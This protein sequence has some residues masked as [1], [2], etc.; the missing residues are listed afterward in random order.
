MR[1]S[2]TYVYDAAER[3]K[4]IFTDAGMYKYVYNTENGKVASYSNTLSGTSCFYTYDIMDRVIDITYAASDGSLIRALQYGY[5]TES[6]ITNKTIIGGVESGW[7]LAQSPNYQYDSLGRLVWESLRDNTRFG[8]KYDLAGNR[9]NR[10]FTAA[11]QSNHHCQDSNGDLRCDTCDAYFSQWESRMGT[12]NRLTSW[13][14]NGVAQYDSAGNTTNLVNGVGDLQLDLEWD[15][16][17][18][19]TSATSDAETI[20]YGYNMLGRKISRTV[21]ENSTGETTDEE[22][23]IYSGEHIVADMDAEGRLLRSYSY[24]SGIDN[25]LSMTVYTTTQTNTYYYLKDLLNTVIALVDE[26]GKVVES[27]DYD[28]WGYVQYVYNAAGGAPL[29][30]S[31]YGNRYRFQGREFDESTGLYYFRARWYHAEIGRW[32][33]KDPIGISGG[34]NLYVFCGNNPVNFVDPM[35]L[36]QTIFGDDDGYSGTK[37]Y[38]NVGGGGLHGSEGQ[39][40]FSDGKGN[41]ISPETVYAQ[42][43]ADGYK[44]GT[45]IKLYVCYAAL[46][47]GDAKKLAQLAKASVLA[48][49]DLVK[50]LHSSFLGIKFNYWEYGVGEWKNIPSCGGSK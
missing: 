35:G 22:Y 18:R 38:W 45:P 13:L 50:I 20:T 17:Y 32:L 3:L 12:G 29:A 6:M 16:R 23:Y 31:F 33:S 44:D 27:Y 36:Y 19:M 41:Q 42:M 8:Y 39:G 11:D 30:E 14:Y 21:T 46:P 7:G 28:A 37:G 15:E 9:T 49:T 43:K 2:P 48:N 4:T 1:D 34:L 10:V 26:N 24:G 5:N 47:G 25:I 40:Y